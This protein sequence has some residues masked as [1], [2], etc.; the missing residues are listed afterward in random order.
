MQ[1]FKATWTYLR[2]SYKTQEAQSSLTY[3]TYTS[4]ILLVQFLDPLQGMP[5]APFIELQYIFLPAIKL[6]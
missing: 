6:E 1:I 3:K 2:V 4:C 5:Q